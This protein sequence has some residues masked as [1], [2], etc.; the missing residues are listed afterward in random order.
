M[1]DM[2]ELRREIGVI[3]EKLRNSEDSIL[4]ERRRSQELA[5]ADAESRATRTTSLRLG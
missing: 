5:A 4:A 1:P 3:K 2:K